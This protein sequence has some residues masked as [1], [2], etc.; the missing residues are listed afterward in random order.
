MATL[1]KLLPYKN[2]VRS[3]ATVLH[4]EVTFYFP[5]QHR[6]SVHSCMWTSPEGFNL[7]PL[8]SSLHSVSFSWESPDCQYSRET[9]ICLSSLDQRRVHPV[10]STGLLLSWNITVLHSQIKVSSISLLRSV[11]LDLLTS[12]MQQP[13]VEMVMTASVRGS[14][15]L[16]IFFFSSSVKGV[17]KMNALRTSEIC[18][19]IKELLK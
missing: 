4:S 3:L 2:T 5:V 8:E 11:K 15:Q 13:G 10:A 18:T 16:G 14:I 7:L 9:S 1:Y 17:V 6:L 12:W 19:C